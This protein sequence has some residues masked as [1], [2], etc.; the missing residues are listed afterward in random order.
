MGFLYY[1]LKD[2]SEKQPYSVGKNI[3][4]NNIL[5]LIN[6]HLCSGHEGFKEL[7][8]VLPARIAAYNRDVRESN[9]RVRT[10]ITTM[11]S[12]MQKLETEV[13]KI[14][15]VNAV[16]GKSREV[17]QAEWLVKQRLAD[18]WKYAESFTNDLDINTNSIDNRNAINDL[19]SSLREKIE[20]VRVTIEHETKRLT[21]LSKKEREELT[22]TKDFLYAEIDELKKRLHTTI[23]KH[24][25]DLVEQL[26]KSVREILGQ[27][28]SLGTRFRDH[29]ESLRKW[30]EQAENLID[31]AEKN[32]DLVSGHV[33]GTSSTYSS[34]HKAAMEQF[35]RE[36]IQVFEAASMAKSEVEKLVQEA[37]KLVGQLDLAIRGDLYDM[38]G[39][40]DAAIRECLDNINSALKAGINAAKGYEWVQNAGPAVE[41]MEKAVIGEL[42]G[43]LGTIG[44]PVAKVLAQAKK[45]GKDELGKHLEWL[46]NDLNRVVGHNTVESTDFIKYLAAYFQ[47]PLDKELPQDRLNDGKV[48]IDPKK[49]PF[50]S[51]TDNGKKQ[52]LEAAISKIKNDG[53]A[54]LQI[55]D[56]SGGSGRITRDTFETH[57]NL[58]THHLNELYGAIKQAAEYSKQNL[59]KLKD[60][61]FKQYSNGAR[62]ANDSIR[63]IFTELG[64]LHSELVAKPINKVKEF[65]QKGA[66]QAEDYYARYLKQESDKEVEKFKNLIYIHAQMQYGASVKSLLQAFCEKSIDELYGLPESITLDLDSGFKGFMKQMETEF[67]DKVKEVKQ[68]DVSDSTQQSPLGQ[69][70][71]YIHRAFGYFFHGLKTQ[72][73]FMPNYEFIKPSRNAL[74]ELLHGLTNSKHYDPTFRNNLQTFDT[75]LHAFSP[76]M[77][78]GPPHPQLLDILKTGMEALAFEL[79]KAYVNVYEGTNFV[80]DW[81]HVIE[82]RQK[83]QS[84]VAPT[85]SPKHMLTAD[86]RDCAKVFMTLLEILGHDLSEFYNNC[87]MTDGTWRDRKISETYKSGINAFG[88]FLE[89]CGYTIPKG[90]G[91]K[92]DG[93]LR[94]S[95]DMK[96]EKIYERLVTR[97]PIVAANSHFKT[98]SLHNDEATKFSMMGLLSCITGHLKEYYQVCHY[99]TSDAKGQPRSVYEML[100]WLSGLPNNAVHQKLSFDYFAELFDKPKTEENGGNA[101]GDVTFENLEDRHLDAYPERITVGNLTTTLTDIC[102]QSHSVLTTIL[103]HGQAAGRYACD[104]NTNEAKLSYPSNTAACF[105]MLVDIVY[106]LYDQ[107]YFLFI[108]CERTSD[109][110]SWRD[111]WYG[112]YVGGSSWECNTW[113]CHNLECN[114]KANQIANQSDDQNANQ[115]CDQHPKCGLKSPLQS[116]LEDGLP[117]FLPHQFTKPGCKLE[118]TVSKHRGVPCKTPMGFADISIAASHTKTG[119][120]ISAEL[121]DF[122]GG[123]ETPLGK[124][125]SYFICILQRTPQTLGD[126]FAFYYNFIVGWD[127]SGTKHRSYAFNN[128]VTKAYFGQQ[129]SGLDVKSLLNV[130]PSSK[131]DKGNLMCLVDC[132]NTAQGRVTCGRYLQSFGFNTWRMF[133][134][135]HAGNYLSWIVYLTETFYQLLKGLY[136]E[137]CNNCNKPG[138]RCHGKICPDACT[139]KAAY[140]AEDPQKSLNGQYHIK[141]C[142]S[143]AT[144]PFTRP[145]LYKHGFTLKS[146]SNLSGINGDNTKRT[147]QDFC[148]ELKIIVDE[149][150]VLLQ[151][152][153]KID[154]FLL[155]IR[156]PFM[157]LTLALWLLSLLY[158][159]HIMVTRL[160]LLHIKSHLHSPSSHRIAAQSLLAE[161]RVSKLNRVFY[162]QP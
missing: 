142:K 143:I 101:D 16:A 140:K 69:A 76:M 48:T 128:A 68:I 21:E 8:R 86:G 49:F 5:T 7:F 96:G 90:E 118:C 32:V 10:I 146:L 1:L 24:I 149:K 12:N 17:A 104:F 93:E 29:I 162:L 109:T 139:V 31:D 40:V 80:T 42:N 148:N 19:N 78:E 102:A 99:A 35:E 77:L 71:H 158:L 85:D 50:Y 20:N 92:Q 127:Q 137:C 38:K 73:N 98:C 70:A 22:A 130:E 103:G 57:A 54:A 28:E 82:N 81:V 53:V 47:T 30:M 89:Y 66:K 147:C 83:P 141:D 144:C 72:T 145:T 52:A 14:T 138:T 131:H 105:D 55:I 43:K 114:Q 111:C 161:A 112:R 120:E 79:H 3:L 156:F 2:V 134:D 26:K 59:R 27:L 67:I 64:D 95:S 106:R 160:D 46:L 136:D 126:M 159:I 132:N 150:S 23:D 117:G 18:C 45:S 125:C 51:G 74:A 154:D 75:L 153:Y 13:S 63:K 94:C 100:Q 88:Q 9:N 65:L 37:T 61:R 110:N 4:I 152:F 36:A 91:S 155:A 119:A 84:G 87:N 116:F 33:N 135:K 56:A 60:E 11:Q 133:A 15:I 108:Q 58:V 41:A 44:E 151:M 113:Q 157:T 107:L 122:C 34:Q 6:N 25:K 121:R 97:I 115:Q 124:M 39:R 62:D 123:A 129:Y